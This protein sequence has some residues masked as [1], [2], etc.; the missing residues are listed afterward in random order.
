MLRPA[1]ACALCVR[2]CMCGVCARVHMHGTRTC[3][4]AWLAQTRENVFSRT[5]TI[6]CVLYDRR[7]DARAFLRNTR[8]H[9]HISTSYTP[10]LRPHIHAYL[11][12]EALK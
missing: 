3:A 12:P 4:V 2:A 1:R 9:Q 6:E 11:I 10:T 7:E 8:E 5:D